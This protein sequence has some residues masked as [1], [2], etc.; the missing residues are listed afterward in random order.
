MLI[1]AFAP[2]SRSPLLS[3]LV[4]V[5]PF[6]VDGISEATWPNWFRQAPVNVKDPIVL[7]NIVHGVFESTRTAINNQTASEQFALVLFG[8][9]QPTS[10][11]S[12]LPTMLTID[13]LYLLQMLSRVAENLGVGRTSRVYPRYACPMDM[14][15]DTQLVRQL[16]RQLA[17]WHAL[18]RTSIKVC[19]EERHKLKHGGVDR[20][21]AEEDRVASRRRSMLRSL[22][23]VTAGSAWSNLLYNWHLASFYLAWFMEGQTQ[24]PTKDNV[25]KWIEEAS[26]MP[27]FLDKVAEAGFDLQGA[28]DA[29]PM[30]LTIIQTNL[31]SDS[32]KDWSN[33]I[34]FMLNIS[35][36]ACLMT[37]KL[38]SF[39]VNS[40]HLTLMN[41]ALGSHPPDMIVFETI[42]WEEMFQ[43]ANG[44]K[45]V[46][47]ALHDYGR[48]AEHLY[49]VTSLESSAAWFMCSEP[50][51]PTL[52]ILTTMD[53]KFCKGA[54]AP[55]EQPQVALTPEP[56]SDM[57]VDQESIINIEGS[58][59]P[60]VSDNDDLSMNT[61]DRLMNGLPSLSNND[62][63]TVVSACYNWGLHLA[64][65]SPDYQM[66]L[67]DEQIMAQIATVNTP[68]FDSGT[69]LFWEEYTGLPI[70]NVHT[71]A[72][73]LQEQ[74]H[75]SSLPEVL[76][77]SSNKN[78]NPVEEEDSSDDD[79]T[80][81]GL[82]ENLAAT[83]NS[84]FNN[85]RNPS[86]Q[87]DCPM[88]SPNESIEDA[89]FDNDTTS[90]Q[91]T[92]KSPRVSTQN[93]KIVFTE[94]EDSSD[95]DDAHSGLPE[96]LAA[97]MNSAFNNNRNPSEQ[98]DS[99]MRSPNES[100]EDMDLDSDKT[101]STQ[102]TEESPK[103][104]VPCDRAVISPRSYENPETV[105]AQEVKAQRHSK[106]TSMRRSSTKRHH[107]TL[108]LDH[109]A[110]G[111]NSTARIPSKKRKKVQER[112][113][114]AEPD[115]LAPGP[116]SEDEMET[117]EKNIP[118]ID[119]TGSDTI[120]AF[121]FKDILFSASGPPQLDS[122]GIAITRD[123]PQDKGLI[124]KA[125]DMMYMDADAR[126][127][128]AKDTF[129]QMVQT[130]EL[131]AYSQT[132]GRK[133]LDLTAHVWSMYQPVEQQEKL[134]QANIVIQGTENKAALIHLDIDGL[135]MMGILPTRVLQLYDLSR[136]SPDFPYAA[137]ARS[138]IAKLLEDLPN[139]VLH[140]SHI[141]F[142]PSSVTGFPGFRNLSTSEAAQAG[143]L[144]STGCQPWKSN[145]LD[146]Y[147]NYCTISSAGSWTTISCSEMAIYMVVQQGDQMWYL[148]TDTAG[149]LQR[150][151]ALAS[152]HPAV[153]LQ[154]LQ[155]E[156]RRV[157]T[158]DILILQPFTFYTT[159]TF[160]DSL[161]TGKYFLTKNSLDASILA[162]IHH[163]LSSAELHDRDYGD[164]GILFM[165]TQQFWHNNFALNMAG[166]S[167]G[168]YTKL[169]TPD[170]ATW[171]GLQKMVVLGN[172]ITYMEVLDPR[173][174]LDLASLSAAAH[175]E[176][177]QR[178]GHFYSQ[179]DAALS[180]FG[181]FRTLFAERFKVEGMDIR[182]D[183]F[184]ASLAYF[185]AKLSAYNASYPQQ[186]WS[187][188]QFEKKLDEAFK[189][190]M[191]QDGGEQKSRA[192]MQATLGMKGRGE[193]FL[194]PASL[195]QPHDLHPTK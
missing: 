173:S 84:A 8:Y 15:K 77:L 31:S 63:S 52:P 38:W 142:R 127:L 126:S 164:A 33:P 28:D 80:H 128:N 175:E 176:E 59:K 152:F 141:P 107:S 69:P 187:L 185:G 66:D 122:T 64:N 90:I 168:Q 99:P 109:A 56:T 129:Y 70:T 125:Y 145:E 162:N 151:D 117:A 48:R 49:Q 81:S 121:K 57:E 159:L 29:A 101:T 85:N 86:E 17:D 106:I 76:N 150:Q 177:K 61:L 174:Y 23:Y 72:G 53:I 170:C 147:L 1:S 42:V 27:T 11:S 39:G 132:D 171:P 194:L 179:H 137:P 67:Q 75:G 157:R 93:P 7:Q 35:S 123:N 87:R 98:R 62:I 82:P 191:Q 20:S 136:C 138:T 116:E 9:E 155:W 120:L 73:E 3:P 156:A 110:R 184:W 4:K 134:Q 149:Y 50:G 180:V 181:Q 104:I 144:S 139:R 55:L 161:V 186:R 2:D 19:L 105:F 97:T 182:K 5:F 88:R 79:D 65:T 100:I 24:M 165:Q 158:G 146:K 91:H 130:F 111:G 18:I 46:E 103:E 71:P 10:T 160:A 163:A 36:L 92:E 74:D 124:F 133:V 195:I 166:G 172:Y 108:Q 153:P 12:K 43:A 47:R 44:K 183:I 13:P 34:Q 143:T 96:N 68:S 78:A 94:E 131:Q 119:L 26:L 112:D 192:D 25:L 189:R 167:S 32:I 21:V 58:P 60:Q 40:V 135:D 118:V 14:K 178:R 41:Q 102:C 188:E 51:L 45:S 140:T 114:S 37:V 83:M 148:G 113:S 89:D 190:Y 154:A 16:K 115:E 22:C 95:D 193:T 6:S 169:H 54:E 30:D